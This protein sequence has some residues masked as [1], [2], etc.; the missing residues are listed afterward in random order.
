MYSITSHESRANASRGHAV[1][2][3]V[4]SKIMPLD[5]VSLPPDVVLVGFFESISLSNQATP[6]PR[7]D[8]T[9]PLRP[10]ASRPH[11]SARPQP[12]SRH[13]TRANGA[14]ADS[15]QSN[16]KPTTSTTGNY[17]SLT[18]N[19]THAALRSLPPDRPR[20]DRLLHPHPRRSHL[21]PPRRRAGRHPPILPPRRHRS[22]ARLPRLPRPPGDRRGRLRFGGRRW[23]GCIRPN[24]LQSQVLEQNGSR[25]QRKRLAVFEAR[26][27]RNIQPRGACYRIQ[28]IRRTRQ[29]SP[30][31]NDQR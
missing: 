11:Q 17:E 14:R 6:P 28:A 29:G 8:R 18:G 23:L 22:L 25:L 30:K 5:A 2:Y 31:L 21:P 13:R 20:Q 10:P 24:N 4:N 16:Q 26:N 15:F 3:F 7:A 19:R 1:N 27:L 9:H 12:N